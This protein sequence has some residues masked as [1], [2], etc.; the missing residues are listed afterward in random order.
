MNARIQVAQAGSASTP[1]QPP[2]VVK[3]VKPENGQAINVELG[4]DQAAKLDLSGVANEKIT[5]VHVGESLVILFDNNATVTVHPFFDSTGAVA[6][7]LTVEVSPG[8]DL[9]GTDFASVFPITTDQSVLPA[10]GD[11]TAGRSRQVRISSACPS[12]D[13]STPNPLPLLGPEMLPNFV[14]V[15][16]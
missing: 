2:R 6:Q 3:V 5:L 14:V 15:P 8:R 9:S 11:A 4:Y 10:A 1:T 13:L 16:K 12:I 7:N